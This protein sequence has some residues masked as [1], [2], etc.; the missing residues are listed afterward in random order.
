MA[1]PILNIL[2][3][4]VLMMCANKNFLAVFTNLGYLHIYNIHGVSLS[5]PYYLPDI[6]FLE[7]NNQFS[8]LSIQVTGEVF[9]WDLKLHSSL[10]KI[11]ILSLFPSSKNNHILNASIDD[12]N[13]L[14]LKTTLDQ[15][16]RYDSKLGIFVIIND[17]KTNLSKKKI[18]FDNTNKHDSL[19]SF[20]NDS[21][22]NIILDNKRMYQYYSNNIEE[23][24]ITAKVF[25]LPEYWVLFRKYVLLLVESKNYKKF[26]ELCTEISNL[27]NNLQIGCNI[28]HLTDDE[29]RDKKLM[30]KSID[31][32]IDNEIGSL[33][34]GTKDQSID[35]LFTKLLRK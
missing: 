30:G 9:I 21:K 32:I 34:E 33:I 1:F 11:N 5:E 15:L 18:I 13:N 19:L 8:L 2:N 14:I 17:F 4:K 24:L 25:N 16:L 22:S 29:R 7:C 10:L 26:K 12:F 31:D 23:K 3:E 6:C 20:E 27:R 28:L 35:I